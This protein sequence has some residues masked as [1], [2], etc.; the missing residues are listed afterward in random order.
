MSGAF[1]RPLRQG[2]QEA[3]LPA[4]LAGEG[5]PISYL[6]AARSVNS[7]DSGN[8]AQTWAWST[9]TTQAALSLTANSLTSGSLLALTSTGTGTTG[10]LLKVTSASTAALAS[11]LVEFTFS[12]AHT[13]S[14]LTVTS[15]TQ[16][17]TAVSITASGATTGSAL[18]ILASALTSGTGVSLLSSGTAGVTGQTLFGVT[19]SGANAAPGQVTYAG[20]VTNAHTGGGTNVALQLSATGGTNNYGLVVA[21]GRVGIGTTDPAVTLDVFLGSSG[22]TGA[23]ARFGSSDGNFD[24]FVAGASPE[25]VTTGSPGDLSV[26]VTGGALYF[27]RSGVASATGWRALGFAASFPYGA[28]TA[29]YTVAAEDYYLT[30]DATG[31]SFTITLPLAATVGA[32]K[33][34]AVKRLDGTGNTVAIARSGADTIDGAASLPVNV[35]YRAYTLISDGVSAWNVFSTL[36]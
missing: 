17:G 31:G 33:A 24:L 34:V 29:N 5:I 25:T 19:L 12:G 18:L 10:S 16:T 11:G 36:P 4:F 26:D 21:S 15:A 35:Q 7:L 1:D 13:G 14:G 22:S 2:L 30:A 27:K 3:P 20:K 8:F 28:K 32:G 9:A 6:R 23:T